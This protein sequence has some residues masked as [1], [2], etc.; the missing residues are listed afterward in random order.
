LKSS[1]GCQKKRSSNCT[2]TGYFSATGPVLA[3]CDAA[4]LCVSA[5]A[6]AAVPSAPYLTLPEESGIPTF[7]FVNRIDPDTDRVADIVAA[8]Q[9]YCAHTIADA[10][11]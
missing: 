7:L 5:E 8:L 4:V 10:H 9:P 3:A 11:R 6:D 2:S 1:D